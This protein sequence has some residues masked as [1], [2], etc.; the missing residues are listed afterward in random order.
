VLIGCYPLY[1]LHLALSFAAGTVLRLN[2]IAIYLGTHVNNPLT[3]PV[4][5]FAELQVGSLVLRGRFH[6]LTIRAVRELDPA[7]FLADLAVGAT[8]LG[9]ALGGLLGAM[10]FRVSRAISGGEFRNRLVEESALAFLPSGFIYWELARAKLR[11][12]R[13]FLEILRRGLLPE[14]GTAV[15]VRCGRGVLLAV[16]AT[17]HRL[18]DDRPRGWPVAPRRIE[19][20]GYD[21]RRRA[22]EV[23]RAALAEHATIEEGDAESVSLPRCEAI[24]AIDAL[25]R[26][27]ADGRE[28]FLSRVSAALGPGGKLIVR[29]RLDPERLSEDLRQ[30]GLVTGTAEPS[31]GL[32]RSKFLL[33]AKKRGREPGE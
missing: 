7:A 5:I 6:E 17:F 23:A 4:L 20:V 19:L 29:D 11:L 24:V 31:R 3:A 33:V 12:D 21:R 32:L 2:R 8:V 25:G 9:V 30:H 18:A 26:M 28:R 14:T 13:T 27:T 22:V 10:T 1:G 16:V 15:D